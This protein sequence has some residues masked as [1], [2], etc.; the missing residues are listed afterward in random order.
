[1]LFYFV[2][3]SSYSYIL[4]DLTI[5]FSLVDHRNDTA[6]ASNI[7][8][9]SGLPTLFGVRLAS[10]DFSGKGALAT[11]PVASLFTSARHPDTYIRYY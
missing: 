11:Y 3:H 10:F 9:S 8:K 5:S 7:N 6:T 1:M 4:S 2:F